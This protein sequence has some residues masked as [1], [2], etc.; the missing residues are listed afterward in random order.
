MMR[1]VV[2][3]VDAPNRLGIQEVEEPSPESSEALVRV[4]EVSLNRGEVR[5]TQTA[6]AGF[7]PGWDLAGTVEVSAR[8]G[9]GAPEG[10]RVV[11]FLPSGAWAEHAA[12]PTNALA[13]LPENVSSARA[14]TLPM[15]GLTTPYALRKGG[16]LLG[17]TVLVT[18]ASG[19]AGDFAVQLARMA[20]ARVVAAIRGRSHRQETVP[21]R[22]YGTARTSKRGSRRDSHLLR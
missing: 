1:A 12:V 7:R 2:V 8:D 18:G 10:S 19:G 5:R 6:E 21:G 4:E 22:G 9:S 15:A 16:N 17:R 11:G 20:G 3:D 14:A 13:V